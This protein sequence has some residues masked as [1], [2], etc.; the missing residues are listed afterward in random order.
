MLNA[1]KAILVGLLI[2]SLVGAA[3]ALSGCA[4]LTNTPAS[5]SNISD[6]AVGVVELGFYRATQT[7][8]NSTLVHLAST[9]PKQP[10]V[11]EPGG[12]FAPTPR[13]LASCSAP[14]Y[15]SLAG[16]MTPL[17][18]VVLEPCAVLEGPVVNVET[19]GDWWHSTFYVSVPSPYVNAFSQQDYDSIKVEVPKGSR[20]P[21]VGDKVRVT[22][23]ETIDLFW[24]F[25]AVVNGV[26]ANWE[27]VQ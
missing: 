10:D 3:M 16:A 12:W 2:G 26:E 20:L 6:R 27:V 19:D 14:S 25:V 5:K 18:Y 17:G 1:I 11:V 8:P 7:L 13:L 22:G 23:A 15:Y 4:T 9:L 21:K 24:G